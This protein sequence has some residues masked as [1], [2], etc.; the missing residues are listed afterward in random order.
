VLPLALLDAKL[1]C[2]MGCIVSCCGDGI[3]WDCA[4]LLRAFHFDILWPSQTMVVV[5][6][7]DGLMM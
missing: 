1:L 2:V 7:V 4:A 6:T 5:L 3:R